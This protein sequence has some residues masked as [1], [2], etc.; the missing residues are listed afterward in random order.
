MTTTI[1]GDAVQLIKKA[2]SYESIITD[3][4]WPNHQK[5]FQSID[6]AAL[7]NS[8]LECAPDSVKRVVIVLGG[9]SDPRFL[10]CVPRRWPFLK[11]CFLEFCA[12]TR[13]GRNLYTHLMAYAFGEWP[14]SKPGARVIPTKVMSTESEKRLSWHPTPMR[15]KHCKWLVRWFGEGG[16]IDP[17]MGSGSMGVA[18]KELR[19]DYFGIELNQDYFERATS[20]IDETIEPWC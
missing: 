1:C 17:F 20:R 10:E 4:I 5:V 16:V 15:V 11:T 14:K 12:P 8:T 7:L 19:Q 13:K 6:A 3:P 9:D 18:C 2:P